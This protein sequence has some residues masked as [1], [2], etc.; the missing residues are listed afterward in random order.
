[1][2]SFTGM[3]FFFLHRKE[4]SST[5]TNPLPHNT[6]TTA[7]DSFPIQYDYV[8]PPRKVEEINSSSHK[9]RKKEKNSP[10]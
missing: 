4:T 9:K 6:S 10:D 5:D 3:L 8:F 7:S 1:M 2:T